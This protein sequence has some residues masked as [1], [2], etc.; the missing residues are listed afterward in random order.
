MR[1]LGSYAGAA[2]SAH[3]FVQLSVV[4]TRFLE[5]SSNDKPNLEPAGRFLLGDEA[6]SD[7]FVV[8]GHAGDR[9]QLVDAVVLETFHFFVDDEF[10][11]LA[12]R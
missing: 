2:G 4:D 10:P 12:L 6:R 9:N 11:F 5:V 7:Y 1:S 8:V 3:R